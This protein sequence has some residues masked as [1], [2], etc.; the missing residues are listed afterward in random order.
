MAFTEQ[1]RRA[2]GGVAI[3]VTC[4]TIVAQWGCWRKETST[5][6]AQSPPT[7]PALI[8]V[9][10]QIAKLENRRETLIPLLEKAEDEKAELVA[11][12][13]DAGVAKSSDLKNNPTAQRY[14]V[15]LQKV[16]HDIKT[17]QGEIGRLDEAITHAKALSRRA[18]QDKVRI[19]DEE[20][21]ALSVDSGKDSPPTA[22]DPAN[23]D[24]LLA[25][26]L[27]GSKP[28]PTSRKSIVGKWKIEKGEVKGDV[29]FSA[30]G[31]VIFTWFHTGL[32]KDW[33]DTGKYSL[34]RNSL[35]I[36]ASGEYGSESEREI[37]FLSGDELLVTK[38]KG[39][40]FTWLF[41]R[42]VRVK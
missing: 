41:G 18:N 1:R 12:L 23:L 32:K 25:N 28:T 5:N 22:S 40:Q 20:L 9:D 26:E 3:V 7:K 10:Q 19:S 39:H 21:A 24:A 42:L 29:E 37:E 27:A 11:K 8:E 4:L 30:G 31:T 38:P 36:K 16:S 35:K 33:V 13:R 6:T 15:A 34:N 14:A 2:I 17:L